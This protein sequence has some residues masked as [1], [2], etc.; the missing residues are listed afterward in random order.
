M[1]IDHDTKRFIEETIDLIEAENW[2]DVYDETR[3]FGLLPAEINELT[4]V[5]EDCGFNPID[6]LS[7]VP[8]AYHFMDGRM[9]EF[10][11]KHVITEVRDLA[12]ESC[13]NLVRIIIPEGCKRIGAY[14]FIDCPNVKE[15]RLPKSIEFIA[16]NAFGSTL[17]NEDILIHAPYP[18]YANEWLN[19]HIY[20]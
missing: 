13:D 1:I 17:E 11:P 8:F 12:F 10:A 7:Y 15:L 5:L 16:E 4:C 6:H 2:S 19:E 14:A 18:S 9:E 20:S 3:H